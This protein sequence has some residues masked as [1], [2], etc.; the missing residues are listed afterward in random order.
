MSE[1]LHPDH[2]RLLALASA[3]CR[4]RDNAALW[5]KAP[6]DAIDAHSSASERL[7][8]ELERQLAA[9]MPLDMGAWE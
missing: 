3:A 8:S 5:K 9:V 1:P 7:W 4:A 2:L 6:H